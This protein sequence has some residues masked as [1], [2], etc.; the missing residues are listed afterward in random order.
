MTH[1]FDLIQEGEFLWAA[2]EPY[3]RIVGETFA[4]FLLVMSLLIIF[5]YFKTESFTL[6]LMAFITI[7]GAFEL[8]SL[9]QGKPNPII[10]GLFDV[11]VFIF[12]VGGLAFVIY[13]VWFK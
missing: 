13:R 3:S 4:L 12:L 11:W 5:I 8:S 6:P 10:P 7:A 1:T 9:F 2:V